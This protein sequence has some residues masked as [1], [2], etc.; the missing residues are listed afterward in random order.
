MP[1][2]YFFPLFILFWWI[3]YL[4]RKDYFLA[5]L[6]D[7]R[8]WRLIHFEVM[9]WAGI[10]LAKAF[11]P[12]AF[13]F[14][15][16][17]FSEIIILMTAVIF[18][19]LFSVL[20]NNIA[21]LEIDAVT[22][23]KRPTVTLLIPSL[24]YKILAC[25][26]FCMAAFYSVLV[27]FTTFFLMLVFIGNYFL[28]SMPPLRLKRI[29][30]FS[31]AL[32]ALNSLILLMAGYYIGSGTIM[33]P[34]KISLFFMILMT[35]VLNFIDIKDYEGDKRAGIRTLPAVLGLKEAKLLISFFFAAAYVFISLIFPGFFLSLVLAALGAGQVMIINRES[36]RERPVFLLYFL[37]VS[38]LFCY[39]LKAQRIVI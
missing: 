20:T 3:F 10:V 14:N 22:N 33:V 26:F 1:R 25:I 12:S 32:I 34:G 28:Y 8:P 27:D 18:A 7:I 5:V 39:L 29:T 37:T 24:H 13:S 4:Y 11:L 15:S 17:K 6:R 19:W 36:Y 2:L 23:R 16:D 21:D 30:F 35:A 9:P 31:K 38:F